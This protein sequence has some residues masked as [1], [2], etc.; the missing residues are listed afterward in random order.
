VLRSIVVAEADVND[1][2]A[3]LIDDDRGA[4]VS[5]TG[6]ERAGAAVAASAGRAVKKSLLELGRT[7]AS[8]RPGRPAARGA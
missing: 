4:A 2:T 1:I 6:S 3:A 7:A 5:L 8:T